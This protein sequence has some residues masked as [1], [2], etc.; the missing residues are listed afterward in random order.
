MEKNLPWCKIS[1]T[2]GLDGIKESKDEKN[3][4]GT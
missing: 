3:G 2:G 1:Q 4:A